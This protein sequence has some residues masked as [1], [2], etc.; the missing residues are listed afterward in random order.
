[1]AVGIGRVSIY[2]TARVYP[3]FSFF[4]FFCEH[5]DSSISSIVSHKLCTITS[6]VVNLVYSMIP[7]AC[8]IEV[9][10]TISALFEFKL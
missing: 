10:E 1:M 2:D 8:F 9:F 7:M 5:F 3:L 6:Y 4:C